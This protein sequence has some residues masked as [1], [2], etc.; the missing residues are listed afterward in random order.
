MAHPAHEIPV[1]GGDSALPFG[2]HAHVAAQTGAAGGGGDGGAGLN[3]VLNE[4]L[5]HGLEHD[6]LGSGDDHA[7]HVGGNL[8]ASH[9][10][11]SDAQVLNPAVGA[12]A[13]DHLVD[14]Q[15][16]HLA[17]D[18]RILRQM[19]HSHSGLQLIQVNDHFPDVLRVGI[20]LEGL[21]GAVHPAVDVLH[22]LLLHGENAVLA[23]GLNGHVGDGEPVIHG[24]GGNALAGKLQRLIQRAVHADLADQMQ[25]DILA[26]HPAAGLAL[27]HHLDRGRHLEPS[28]AGD[29]TGSHVR[30]THAGG[31]CAQRAIG[32]G[33]G[34]RAH[35]D[36][37]GGA[38]ALLGQQGVLH[39]HLA[40]VEEIGDVVLVGKFPGLLA[41]L[42][43]LDVLAGGVVVQNDGDLVLV[44]DLGEPGLFKLG[45]GHRSG[46]VVAQDQ[47][48]LGL[49]ELAYFY[50]I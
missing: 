42:G 18:L 29:H 21:T 9:N 31:E 23:A 48:Q 22:G 46:D 33:V 30:G 8:L 17:D 39:A 24:E 14:G 10:G 12:R 15:A 25:D 27:Q 11:R 44:K 34:V 40:Y 43:G 49:D 7:A 36:L 26:A 16:G 47:I 45:D 1:G 32:A 2:H 37:A 28:L 13:D 19:R 4:A 3:E 41:Q 6:L 50:L 38:Q 5:L 35:D 20:G